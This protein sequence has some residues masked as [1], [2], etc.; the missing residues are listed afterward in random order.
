MYLFYVVT[1][2]ILLCIFSFFADVLS[3]DNTFLLFYFFTFKSSL[4]RVEFFHSVHEAVSEL[5][6]LYPPLRRYKHVGGRLAHEALHDD[7]A[8]QTLEIGYAGVDILVGREE[9]E[10]PL[11]VFVGKL[12]A[13]DNLQLVYL[14]NVELQ[15]RHYRGLA[16]VL[17]TILAGQS[18]DDMSAGEYAA[19]VRQFNGSSARLEVEPTGGV[20]G[21][22]GHG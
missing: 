5:V 4:P 16:Y 8:A 18:E 7:V 2:N 21:G 3:Y 20:G 1:T 12:R 11:H 9:F 17:L 10:G 13:A 14:Q 22:G 15:I 19:V 6:V